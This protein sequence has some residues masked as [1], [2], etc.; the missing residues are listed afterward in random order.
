MVERNGTDG[1]PLDRPAMPQEEAEISPPYR[2]QRQQ[3]PGLESLMEVRP[4]YHAPNYR[5]SGKLAGKVALITGGDSGIGRA[6]AVLYAREGADVAVVHLPEEHDDAEE[7]R[8]AVEKEG[9]TC[10]LPPGDL[11]EP[12]FCAEVVERTV[13]ELGGLNVR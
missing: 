13:A 3:R 9:R 1:G 7:T 10:L 11:C 5:G 4:R 6:V 2:F 12:S 8:A